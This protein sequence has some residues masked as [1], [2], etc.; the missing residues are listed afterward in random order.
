[1][2]LGLFNCCMGLMAITGKKDG[3]QSKWLFPVQVCSD[4]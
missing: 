1:V 2:V 4:V 3:Y